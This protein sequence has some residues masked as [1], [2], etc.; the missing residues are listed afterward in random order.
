MPAGRRRPP[1]RRREDKGADMLAQ[2]PQGLFIKPISI[3]GFG[4]L[5]MLVPLCL[6]IS[7][8]YKTIR[9]ERLSAIPL[10]SLSL[11][12]MIVVSM[13]AIGAVLLGV[14]QLLA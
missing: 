9:C 7:I 11:C 14:F 6:A 4:G 3:T 8:V 12:A 1:A 2:L 5:G 10:A 13:L